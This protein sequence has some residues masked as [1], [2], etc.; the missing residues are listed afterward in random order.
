MTKIGRVI[1]R[2]D[3]LFVSLCNQK[4]ASLIISLPFTCWEETE[5]DWQLLNTLAVWSMIDNIGNQHQ[6]HLCKSCLLWKIY[7]AALKGP[8]S[9]ICNSFPISSKP[10]LY[11]ILCSFSSVKDGNVFSCFSPLHLDTTISKTCP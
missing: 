9:K 6:L 11:F 3:V 10:P 4:M 8:K 7:H 5:H 2:P 1:P